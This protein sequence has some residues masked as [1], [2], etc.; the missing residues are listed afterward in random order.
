MNLF[1]IGIGLL[2][3]ALPLVSSHSHWSCDWSIMN[4]CELGPKLRVHVHIKECQED[5]GCV[6]RFNV[7]LARGEQ[8]R[9]TVNHLNM[10][11]WGEKVSI[12]ITHY[13]YLVY[14]RLIPFTTAN[15]KGK[16]LK[17]LI[18]LKELFCTYYSG[19]SLS[20]HSL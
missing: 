19:T 10:M 13:Y 7:S 14:F 18:L 2:A 6:S 9:D 16:V 3:S 5:G 12:F 20:G 17:Y 1:A 11:W 8:Y 15:T 4:V